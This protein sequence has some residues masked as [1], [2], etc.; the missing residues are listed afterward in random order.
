[1]IELLKQQ[2]NDRMPYEEKLNRVRELLQIICLK[3][4]YDRG[5]FDNLSFVGGTALRILFNMRRFSEDLDFSL[6]NKKGYNFSE[7]NSQLVKE[8]KLLGLNLEAKPKEERIVNSSMLKFEGLLKELG[9]SM[10]KTQ[11]FSIKLEIDTNPPEGWHLENTIVNKVYLLNIMHFD[12]PSMFATKLHACFYRKY[13][14]GRDFYDLVWYIGKKTVPNFTVLNNA[15]KQAQ[16]KDAGLNKD[17]F[18]SFLL[19]KI[20][21]INFEET[22]KDV[23][24]FLEDKSELAL[25]D[26]KLVRDSIE[27][28]YK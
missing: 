27:A 20:E 12:L 26:Y 8:F 14:K 22:K 13:L 6:I 11:K 18:K 10:L 5:Y 1:M 17:N 16:G 23:E 4:I 21:K 2:I 24:R 15:F 3:I 25:L 19:E 28:V 9:M 7:L